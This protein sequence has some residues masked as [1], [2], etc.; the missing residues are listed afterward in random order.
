VGGPLFTP[1][2]HAAALDRTLAQYKVQLF[3]F[4]GEPDRGGLRKANVSGYCVFRPANAIGWTSSS[5]ARNNLYW[6]SDVCVQSAPASDYDAVYDDLA[7]NNQT[8]LGIAET[9]TVSQAEAHACTVPA[10]PFVNASAGD[11]HLTANTPS[12][13]ALGSPYDVDKD[14]KPRTTWTR[15]AYEHP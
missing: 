4:R 1:R 6:N 15:G 12:G 5:Q 7:A 8:T 2:A 14:G 10:I 3:H 9:T 11:F 13:Q